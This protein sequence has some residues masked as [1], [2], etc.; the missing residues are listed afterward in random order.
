MDD[1]NIT[2]MDLLR[3]SQLAISSRYGIA[4]QGMPKTYAKLTG[5]GLAERKGNGYVI[6][7][8]GLATV[9]INKEKLFGKKKREKKRRKYDNELETDDYN[10]EV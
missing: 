4:D 5:L 8:T 6:T 2:D 3:L 10:T 7:E 1:Y 9:R